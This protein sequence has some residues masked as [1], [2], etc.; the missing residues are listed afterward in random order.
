[1]LWSIIVYSMNKKIFS[2]TDAYRNLCISD[3]TGPGGPW[4][5]PGIG[6]PNGTGIW[7]QIDGGDYGGSTAGGGDMWGNGS[8]GTWGRPGGPGVIP[9]QMEVNE[10]AAFPGLCGHGRCRNMLGSFTCDC[11]PGYEKVILLYFTVIIIKI[12]SNN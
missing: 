2:G 4:D 11:F 3:A 6:G 10:C 9:G 1:M 5:R 12:N 8:I 7:S